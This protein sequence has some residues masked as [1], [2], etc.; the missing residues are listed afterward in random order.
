MFNTSTF[1][2]F[3]RLDSRSQETVVLSLDCMFES[4]R[5]LF[6][7][8]MPRSSL[9]STEYDSLEVELGLQQFFKRSPDDSDMQ[10]DL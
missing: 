10:P 7:I 8:P 6:K 9:R 5:E 2:F 4:P 3:N 1:F